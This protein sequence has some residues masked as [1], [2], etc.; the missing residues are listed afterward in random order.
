MKMSQQGTSQKFS[1]NYVKPQASHCCRELLLD[2]LSILPN[3]SG[4]FCLFCNLHR[5][6]PIEAHK[7]DCTWRLAEELIRSDKPSAVARP[8][9][10]LLLSPCHL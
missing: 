1:P 3:L 7:P 6:L 5:Q 8:A 2:F 10:H 4:R 9:R